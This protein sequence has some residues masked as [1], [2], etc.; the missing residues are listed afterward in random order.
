MP[1]SLTSCQTAR[2]RR[3]ARLIGIV[4]MACI[5]VL[6]AGLWLPRGAEA[7]GAAPRSAA[8]P[9]IGTEVYILRGLFNVF[10]L[11]MDD[12]AER[13][14][15]GQIRS[16]V[17]NHLAWSGIGQAII[18]RRRAGAAPTRLVLIGHSLGANDVV[19]LARMLGAAGIGVD[20]VITVDPTA[21]GLAPANVRYLFNYYQSSN[22]FGAAV[23][24]GAGFHGMLVNADL[25]TNRRDLNSANV[26]HASIDKSPA[27]QREIIALVNIVHAGRSLA[28]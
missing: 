8:R 22:G 18:G 24:P 3:G 19:S 21:P 4:G 1:A 16:S 9:V 13:L 12:L 20:L 14:Q 11:G 23:L 5:W 27:V 7:R 2:A 28:P 25:A 17:H 10:S 6:L 26:G 15:R